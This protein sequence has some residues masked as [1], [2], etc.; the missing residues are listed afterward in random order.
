[1]IAPGGAVNLGRAT[2]IGE[3]HDQRVVQ[4]SARVQILDQR[5]GG[6]IKRRQH[7]VFQSVKI[8]SVRV[9]VRSFG[10]IQIAGRTIHGCHRHPGLREAARGQSALA[11]NMHTVFLAHGAR[12]FL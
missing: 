1:M 7:V 12:F 2:E 3:H 4:T 5:R 8:I 10:S 6:L 9:K 11:T